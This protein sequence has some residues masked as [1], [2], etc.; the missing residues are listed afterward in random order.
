MKLM[1]PQ[2]ESQGASQMVDVLLDT[3][4]Q[5]PNLISHNIVRNRKGAKERFDIVSITNEARL[6][7]LTHNFTLACT[8]GT[9]MFH[10]KAYEMDDL[11]YDIVLNIATIREYGLLSTHHPMLLTSG[12]VEKE[13]IGIIHNPFGNKGLVATMAEGN[14]SRKDPFSLE[15]L[16]E[17]EDDELQAIPTELLINSTTA[18]ASSAEAWKKLLTTQLF[19]PEGLQA[20]LRSLLSEFQMI[21][22]ATIS[23]TAAK[24][25]EF[26]IEIDEQ[27]WRDK[28]NAGPVRHQTQQRQEVMKEMMTI[29]MLNGIIQPSTA[30]Y[31][32]HGFVVPKKTPGQWRLVIDYR[33]LNL[34]TRDMEHWPIPHIKKL[35]AR[36]GA[37]RPKYFAVLDLTSGYH[38]ILMSAKARELTAFMTPD[39]VYEWCRMPM[40]PKGA[41]SFF[42]RVIASIVLKNLTGIICES[43][44]D[45]IIIY[46]E[47]EESFI[48]NLTQVFERFKTYNVTIH[49]NKGV[50]GKTQVEYV[51]HV[52]SCE[53][54]HFDRK[55]L[56]QVK[57]LDLP[58]TVKQLQSFIGI[59]N[60]FSSHVAGF[61]TI[62]APLTNLLHGNM[63]RGTTTIQ[64]TDEALS[65]FEALKKHVVE[66]PPLF[67]LDDESPILL[68]T[69]ASQYGI[70]AVLLQKRQQNEIVPIALLSKKF[71]KVQL[72][73]ST[74]EKE[75]FAIYHALRT[76]EYMLKDRHFTLHT[77]HR[78][79][80]TLWRQCGLNLKVT[81]WAQA[82]QDFDMEIEHI[83]GI[84][85]IVADALSRA[86]SRE[87]LSPELILSVE[88]DENVP[89]KLWRTI[90]EC[91]NTI[92]GHGGVERTLRKLEENQLVWPGQ[93]KQ[94]RQFVRSCSHCQKM[95]QIKPV[96][97]A[98][99]QMLAAFQPMQQIAIDFIEGLPDSQEGQNTILVIIDTF[100]RFVE[101]YPCRGTG[102][103]VACACVLQHLGRY[104][105]PD[106]ILSDNGPAFISE[107]FETLCRILGAEH[108]KITPYSHEE[109]GIV[110]RANKEVTRFLTDLV[111]DTKVVRN[112]AVVLPLVQRIMNAA[113]H[114]N[115]GATP[116]SLVFGNCIDLDRNLILQRPEL[117][118]DRSE[119][120]T[121][122]LSTQAHL[123]LLISQQSHLVDAI[124]KKM[125]SQQKLIE[126][127]NKQCKAELT[128]FGNGSLVLVQPREGRRAHK[129]APRWLGPKR[130]INI[131]QNGTR[132]T[133]QDLVTMRH[134]DYHV[135]QLKEYFEDPNNPDTP[136][137]VALAD[138]DNVYIVER[139][140]DMR[141]DPKGLKSHLQFLV[142]WAGYDDTTWESWAVVRN[143]DKFHDFLRNHHDTNVRKLL[144]KQFI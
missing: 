139:I 88:D 29:L 121:L 114:E 79:L 56:D 73:W 16:A 4:N 120:S 24:L 19:G 38:Q 115:V 1:W 51:G 106:E 18:N 143:V 101:L 26:E 31:Y 71:S 59:C 144:P 60:W 34:L 53:G 87:E 135:T 91:H 5:G 63:S 76:W 125:A 3:G 90:R 75:A 39:G 136:L 72:R 109:N 47:D 32:S 122:S 124:Q 62:A 81:R 126:G 13:E 80:K 82:I 9:Y 17:I 104:G 8:Q 118:R 44:I 74:P 21:F 77:D 141:G 140:L 99:R 110:E 35:M 7:T 27:Q 123:D 14:R 11:P 119:K 52:I 129:L 40:G 112:W 69:D 107:L 127:L 137:Q 49:P 128:R 23:P 94:V 83:P 98:N 36:I 84:E 25:P 10:T 131:S 12:E 67:F 30:S 70:G 28:R 61:A 68:Q 66:C 117:G 22:S 50:F 113:F 86:V 134:H 58:Q 6:L 93:R 92:V 103:E 15:E 78:N 130:V 102:A 33:I 41:P 116:A 85:N 89:S 45:D 96:I 42:Q 43:Y 97:V 108:T 132:Y 142:Q 64:W 100:S 105:V 133:L 95:Q 65:A 138:H 111:L 37:R 20:K 46:G 54:V 48:H 55:K 57:D 2:E